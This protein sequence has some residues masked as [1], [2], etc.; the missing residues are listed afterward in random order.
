[1]ELIAWLEERV[2]YY[3]YEYRYATDE[4]TRERLDAKQEETKDILE[5]VKKVRQVARALR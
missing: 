4:K 1:M 5:K 3:N 2:E